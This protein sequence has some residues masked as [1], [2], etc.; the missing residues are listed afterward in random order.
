LY[1]IKEWIKGN[2]AE[3]L[4]EKNINKFKGITCEYNFP[5][6]QFYKAAFAYSDMFNQGTMPF[7]TGIRG[8]K[9]FQ[10]DAPIIAGKPFFDYAKHYF[11]ILKDIQNNDKYEG[12]L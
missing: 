3:E 4:S 7:V 8:L 5:F 1:R 12:Y 9:P 6:A 11:E 10:L 2:Y